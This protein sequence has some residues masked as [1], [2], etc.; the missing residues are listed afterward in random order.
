MAIRVAVWI[1]GLFSGF[2]TIGRYG[3]WSTD[4]NLLFILIRQMASLVKRALAEVCTVAVLLVF[5]LTS[6]NRA[7]LARVDSPLMVSGQ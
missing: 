5:L 6:R 7:I 1:Q 2:V 4:I 3:K